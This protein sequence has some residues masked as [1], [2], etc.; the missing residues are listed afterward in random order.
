MYVYIEISI[1]HGNK[2]RL[3]YRGGGGGVAVP[4]YHQKNKSKKIK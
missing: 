1:A 2:T 3:V 4:S